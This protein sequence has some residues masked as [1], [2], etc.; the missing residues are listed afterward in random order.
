MA[1][2][3]FE[4]ASDLVGDLR[5]EY[6]Q[7]TTDIPKLKQTK[8][9]IVDELD[10]M[11]RK[12]VVAQ[13]QISNLTDAIASQT[14]AYNQWQASEMKLLET[15]RAELNIQ[16]RDAEAEQL[17]TEAILKSK[18]TTLV[19]RERAVAAQVQTLT[20]DQED[21]DFQVKKNNAWAKRLSDQ[22]DEVS[23][24]L[25]DVSNLNALLDDREV[26][27]AQSEAKM[28]NVQAEN[29]K[30]IQDAEQD[31]RNAKQLLANAKEKIADNDAREDAIQI[32][33]RSLDTKEQEL[34][35][36]EAALNDRRDV[37]I[38]NGTLR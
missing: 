4:D 1:G 30:S 21:I 3:P 34:N 10:S 17:A 6:T 26:A 28:S 38:A 7:L 12:L 29:A 24:K 35:K 19:A 31:R 11:N 25:A 22:E 20:Q 16:R 5:S 32:R 33:V 9:F 18:E 2:N 15:K 36:R 14:E 8:K 37:M 27:I 13:E 23:K